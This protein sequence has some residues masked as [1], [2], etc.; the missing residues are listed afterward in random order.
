MLVAEIAPPM[1]YSPIWPILGVFGVLIVV[2]WFVLVPLL[3]RLLTR[4]RK[5]KKLQHQA[6]RGR[7][8]TLSAIDEVER[9]TLAG[10]I[11]VRE[12][13]LRLSELVRG[14]ASEGRAIDARTMTLTELRAYG[15]T[16]VADAV[17]QFYPI[18]FQE[19]ELTDIGPAPQIARE[20]VQAWN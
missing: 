9:D 14:F 20:A 11:S 8:A 13:H 10:T 6:I 4:P 15:M 17:A 7:V 12:A 3:S 5:P 2:A 19:E 1:L 18:A 16:I